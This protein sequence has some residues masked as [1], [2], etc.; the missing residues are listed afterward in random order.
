MSKILIVGGV[1]GGASAAARLRRLSEDYEIVLFE[2]GEYISFANCGLPYY[3]GNVITDRNKLFV[4]TKEGMSKRFKLDVRN[5]TEVISINRKKKTVECTDL[6][7]N[8]SY[9]ENYD[10]LILSP[11]AT[12]I[13]PT[14]SGFD[15]EFVF[16]MR[17]VP[18]TDKIYN[19]IN[20]SSVK[21]AVVI[22]GGFIGVEM[23]EN[24]RHRGIEVT[25]VDM[26]NQIMGNVDFEMA[27]F[28]H[29]EMMR[30]NVQL[31]L[32]D[33]VSEVTSDKI[34]KTKK[35]ENIKTDMVILAIGVK[36]ETKLAVDADL[37]IGKRGNILVN[38]QLKTN[39]D[40]IFA[41]GDAIEVKHFISGEKVIIPLAWPAN[42]QGRIVADI[43]N[44]S[45]V[46]YKGTMGT[47]VAKIFDLTMA[48]TGLNEKDLNR[49]GVKY[50]AVHV[51]R[52]NH[53]GYY[54]GATPIV[55][56]II[57]K[58]V[59]GEILGVQGV[60]RDG[61]EKRIDVIATAI[62][63]GAKI[64]DLADIEL[65]YAPPFGSA[66]DPVNIL[67]YVGTNVIDGIYNE[68][69]WYDVDE[70]I[71]NGEYFLDVRTPREVELGKIE[72]TV[73]I[74]L[75]ELR[76]RLSEIPR[77]KDIYV[78]CQVG[79]RGYLAVRILQENGFKKV[80]NL[81][82]GYKIYA[83]AKKCC[84]DKFQ[85]VEQLK[86]K[87]VKGSVDIIADINIDAC[88]L[89]C[90]GPIMQI[91]NAVKKANVGEVIKISAS[92]FGFLTDVASW[93]DKTGNTLLDL[94]TTTDTVTAFVK[95]GTDLKSK[96]VINDDKSTT[97]VC[98]SGDFDKVMATLIIANG[99]VAM[100]HNVSIFFTFWGLNVLRKS[101]KVKVKKTLIEKMFGKMMP[102]GTKKLTLSQMNMLGMGTKMI[103]GIM[104]KKNVFSL[105][106]LLQQAMDSGVKMIACTMSMDLMGIKKEELVDGIE[107]GGVASYISDAEESNVT[108]FI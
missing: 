13:K 60:G 10:Y 77:D 85:P 67:G 73:N 43:I 42:R 92:D 54:P 49:L 9:T 52:N 72:G 93:C 2:R 47:S 18:D 98:F 31:I 56:K 28:L 16:T 89:Q 40:S 20:D 70:I 26:Q 5:N 63:F 50:H 38:D 17:N 82:G 74:E 104:K 76:D 6:V 19:F 95:K 69:H 59:T 84:R 4:E 58:K 32:D 107:Y 105:E 12:P 29:E 3:I 106:E 108:L 100:G 8:K 71:S 96:K 57:F 83:I 80:Y 87:I 65:S 41:V 46:K 79:H 91:A 78:T 7:N 25:L 86:T 48:T 90:P 15:R 45:D 21:H 1:A 101:K 102:R 64:T 75:D 97:M 62:K 33:A 81:S 51:N 35:G 36:G 44:G 22:G 53:A 88:G 103:K 99:S 37:D 66:K 34:V 30:N 24:L 11:G 68:V 61:V 55:F 39:D 23:A 94:S 27:Q 14:V